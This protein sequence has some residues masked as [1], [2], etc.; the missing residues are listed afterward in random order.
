M[1]TL[2]VGDLLGKKL[3]STYSK[4][5]ANYLVIV[6]GS[7]HQLSGTGSAIGGG[8]GSRSFV[9]SSSILG[10]KNNSEIGIYN[11]QTFIGAGKNNSIMYQNYSNILPRHKL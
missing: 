8:I 6:G 2:A 11:G 3:Y 1:N 10:G 7:G 9:S 4:Y 5:V